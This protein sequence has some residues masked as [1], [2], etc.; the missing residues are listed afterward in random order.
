M[1]EGGEGMGEFLHMGGYAPY[2]WSSYGLGAVFLIGMLV[3]SLRRWRGRRAE[4]A[5]ME[6]LRP[7][8]RETAPAAGEG[9]P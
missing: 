3:A 7:R 2:V 9:A 6:D 1:G 8:R 5:R 4:L